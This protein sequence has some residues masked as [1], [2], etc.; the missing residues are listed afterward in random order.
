[1]L[2]N[3]ISSLP[4][5]SNGQWVTHDLSLTNGDFVRLVS[6]VTCVAM[7]AIGLLAVYLAGMGLISSS[8]AFLALPCAAVA[9]WIV[10]SQLRLTEQETPE[11]LKKFQSDASAMSFENV[12][13]TY[14]WKDVLRFGILNP[15]QFAQ[16]YHDQIQGKNLTEVIN[17]YEKT[18]R[19]M[20]RCSSHKFRYQVP[21]PREAAKLWVKETK[22]KSFEEILLHF[23]LDKL[24]KYAVVEP[25][26]L[27]CIDH[28]KRD[29]E[30][31]KVHRDAKI[32]QFQ[33]EF[34][35]G[36]AEFR[37][38]Y[39]AERSQ[40]NDRYN[41][42][43]TMKE[44]RDFEFG[45][46]KEKQEAQEAHS[47]SRGEAKGNF[48]REVGLITNQGRILYNQL[49]NGGKQLYDACKNRLETLNSQADYALR[50]ATAQID[51]RRKARLI[52]LNAAKEHLDAERYHS[53]EESKR[54][55]EE[56][57]H[58]QKRRKEESIAPFEEAFQRSVKDINARYQAF[59]SNH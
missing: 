56:S 23:P 59:L 17:Y 47:R 22:E 19:H 2:Q 8:F 7:V 27:N 13:R 54:R 10:W 11:E 50:V 26:E 52:D 20:S 3:P 38:I 49:S 21:P 33:K 57:I 14:G 48:D 1:M 36:T 29:Y 35:E 24:R 34:D 53:I 16:K 40:A 39:D 37:H 30:S 18:C 45:F 12:I 44:L 41:Q 42:S 28:L 51:D 55:Y 43:Q 25:N 31:L 46:I 15:E 9:F 4:S 58:V 32:A 6:R 5:I